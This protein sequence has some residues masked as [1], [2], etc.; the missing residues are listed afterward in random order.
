MDAYASALFAAQTPDVV[1][2]QRVGLPRKPP[3]RLVV[4]VLH[5]KKDVVHHVGKGPQTFVGREPRR[6]HRRVDADPPTAFRQLHGERGLRQDFPA[7]KGHAAPR[8]AVE[9]HV[10]LEDVEDLLDGIFGP[11]HDQRPAGAFAGA[12]AA[13]VAPFPIDDRRLS[14]LE[15]HGAFR[16]HPRT[17]AA[18][19]AVVGL[20]QQLLRHALRRRVGAPQAAQRA[21]LEKDR[22]P[23]AGA[24]VQAIVLDIL[25]KRLHADTPTASG[26]RILP[27]D[28][29]AARTTWRSRRCRAAPRPSRIP[30]VRP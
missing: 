20:L 18:A 22:R 5:V 23:R 30:A 2:N 21:A 6:F 8:V 3:V 29:H 4:E 11:G 24:V 14:R 28:V 17:E 7:G 12:Q 9:Q 13:V 27:G 19:E 10:P 26:C 1:Q 15:G 25:D 16:A